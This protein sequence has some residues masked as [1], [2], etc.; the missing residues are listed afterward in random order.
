D[1]AA[2]R[3]SVGRDA[4]AGAAAGGAAHRAAQGLPA[5][6]AAGFRCAVG[7]VGGAVTLKHP[8]LRPRI[9]VPVAACIVAVQLPFIHWALRGGAPVAAAVPFEDKFDRATLGDAWWS[10]GGVWR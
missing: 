6:G 1:V 9:A 8:W 5:R 2:D 4:R 7:A 10:N 3:R